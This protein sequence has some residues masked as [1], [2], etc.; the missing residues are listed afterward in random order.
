M[1]NKN[2]CRRKLKSIEVDLSLSQIKLDLRRETTYLKIAICLCSH[3]SN[4][5]DHSRVWPS[6]VQ[7]T[8]TN[9]GFSNGSGSNV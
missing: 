8:C 2:N 4:C 6:V 7:S 5:T 3:Q 1:E 9:P